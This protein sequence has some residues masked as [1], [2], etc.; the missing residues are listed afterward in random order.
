MDSI[1]PCD[2]FRTS[3]TVAAISCSHVL[4]VLQLHLA[5]PDV[6]LSRASGVRACRYST[7]VYS[8]PYLY[9]EMYT[10]RKQYFA[11][12]NNI[13]AE[14]VFSF[15][16][17]HQNFLFSLTPHTCRPLTFS[18]KNSSQN[19]IFFPD[20]SCPCREE[21]C[22]TAMGEESQ[23]KT[24]SRTTVNMSQAIEECGIQ[25]LPP[26]HFYSYPPWTI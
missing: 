12:Y 23:R 25:Y 1:L 16:Y 15:A 26:E 13:V 7:V 3:M 19:C 10:C 14:T 22:H 20:G 24:F 18:K 11:L 6:F 21:S 17:N 8:V 5:W 9:K 4:L 2:R